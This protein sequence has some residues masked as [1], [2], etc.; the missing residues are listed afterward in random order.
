MELKAARQRV[1]EAM[2]LRPARG[3]WGSSA[4]QLALVA[5]VV[6]AIAIAAFAAPGNRRLSQA[7]AAFLF[8]FLVIQ[9]LLEELLF[10]GVVQ[11]WL[12]EAAWGARKALGLSS[13]NWV[14]SLVFVVAHLSAQPLAW[15]VAV[16]VPSLLF[17]HFRDRYN[18]L[19]PAAL[20]HIAWNAAFFLT[21]VTLVR[22][23]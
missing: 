23:G 12:R 18:S 20:L 14:T 8:G 3:V 17:G 21:P 15:A 13:A 1:V 19:L 4:F 9:P 2:G 5:G 16:F 6:V 11:G 10:R 7:S 22:F